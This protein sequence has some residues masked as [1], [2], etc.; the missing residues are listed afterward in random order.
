MLSFSHRRPSPCLSLLHACRLCRALFL[1]LSLSL[2]P[3]RCNFSR[4]C[5]TT[6]FTVVVSQLPAS[7][8]S[9]RLA[10][11][12]YTH[13]VIYR[14]TFNDR[15]ALKLSRFIAFRE[16]ARI[17]HEVA[18]SR[19]AAA[20]AFRVPTRIFTLSTRTWHWRS[21]EPRSLQGDAWR[22]YHFS[23]TTIRQVFSLFFSSPLALRLFRKRV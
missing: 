21:S 20:R 7:I 11:R 16:V 5:P 22:K 1:S 23:E 3:S 19:A 13:T 15:Y 2:Y 4:L 18:A 10:L 8:A 12:T 14:W 17:F 9:I 6:A